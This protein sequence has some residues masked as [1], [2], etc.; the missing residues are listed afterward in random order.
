MVWTGTRKERS[1]RARLTPAP[2]C[3]PAPVLGDARATPV[4]GEF[5]GLQRRPCS[6]PLSSLHSSSNAGDKT[7]GQGATGHVRLRVVAVAG[8]SFS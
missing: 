6:A 1:D 2:P 4:L 7:A 5:T 3:R 8:D